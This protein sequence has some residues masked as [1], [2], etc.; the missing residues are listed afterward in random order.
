MPRG[1]GNGVSGCGM[2][3]IL[4]YLRVATGKE[5]TPGIIAAIQSF[6]SRINLHPHL[7]FL[8]TEGGE[9]KEGKFHKIS[10][11]DEGLIAEFFSREVFSMLLRGRAYQ[12]GACG[13]NS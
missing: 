6:G 5:L 13:E 2:K 3:A 12:P 1:L 8:V 11:F 7:H 4:K 10:R 9:D